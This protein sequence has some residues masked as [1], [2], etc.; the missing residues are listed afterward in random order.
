MGNDNSQSSAAVQELVDV[1]PLYRE[2]GGRK[3][4]SITLVDCR[5]TKEATKVVHTNEVFLKCILENL[6]II[7]F[8]I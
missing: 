8:N 3:T 2:L 1:T 4:T 6:Y 5:N 7:L